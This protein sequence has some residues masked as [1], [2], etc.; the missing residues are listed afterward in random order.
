MSEQLKWARIDKTLRNTLQ[1]DP[2]FISIPLFR[3]YLVA[4][5]QTAGIV[6]KGQL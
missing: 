4:I 6:E 3:R 5:F 1:L 2:L